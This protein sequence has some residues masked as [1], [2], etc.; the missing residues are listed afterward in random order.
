MKRIAILVVV[1]AIMVCAPFARADSDKLITGIAAQ[2][3]NALAFVT[4]EFEPDSAT[5]AAAGPAICIDKSG[6]FMSLSFNATMR[7]AKVKAC[8]LYRSGPDPTPLTA[9][10]VAID[11]ET[12]IAFIKCTDA[13]APKWTAI[14]FADKSDLSLGTQVVSVSLM[15]G[16]AS[17]APYFGRASIS[18]VL[19]VPRPLVYVTGGHLTS[20]CSPVFSA[21]GKAIGLVWRQSPQLVNLEFG[22]QKGLARITPVRETTFFTPAEE[23]NHVIKARGSRRLAWTGILEMRPADKDVLPD[24]KPGIRVVKTV[25]GGPADKAGLKPLDV[26]VQVNGEDL[27]KMPTPALMIQALSWKLRRKDVGDKV[28]FKLATAGK[29]V[30]MTL[31]LMPDGPNEVPRFANQRMGFLARDKA[32]IDP[33]LVTNPALKANGVVVIRVG[34]NSPAIK[35][36]LQ[37]GDVI[38]SIGAQPVGSVATMRELFKNLLADGKEKKVAV[39]VQRR[40]ESVPLIIRVPKKK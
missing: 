33:Y 35:A 39:M 6:L 18:A 36:D 8:K 11:R 15:P 31:E 40:S 34:K 3:N 22:R 21:P 9:E 27:P 24:G 37:P 13:K 23:F 5:Q 14:T 19:N 12:G 2:T 38:T 1:V 20:V 16:D 30:T 4:C 17:R 28:N 26:I 32:L 7:K 29:A 10:L 25:P